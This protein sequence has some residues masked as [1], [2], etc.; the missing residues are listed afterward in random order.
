MV[1]KTFTQRGNPYKKYISIIHVHYVLYTLLIGKC[2]LCHVIK[3]Q[4]DHGLST[5]ARKIPLWSF[6][7]VST[8]ASWTP[9][10]RL[11]TWTATKIGLLKVLNLE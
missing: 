5:G 6:N 9:V 7:H 4:R 1:P 2:A 8:Y 3:V 10:G 11:R